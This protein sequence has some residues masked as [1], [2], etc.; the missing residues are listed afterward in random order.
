MQKIT[1][2]QIDKLYTF[3]KKH[4]VEYYDLQTESVD[5]LSLGSIVVSVILVVYLLMMY[6]MLYV[7]PSKARAHIIK[8]HPEYNL[9]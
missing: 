7:I 2:L 5:H 3:T 4:Y 1:A 9:V 6:I 8:A